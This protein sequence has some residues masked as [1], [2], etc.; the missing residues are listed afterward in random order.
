MVREL[1]DTVGVR[2]GYEGSNGVH[3]V[4][5]VHCNSVGALSHDLTRLVQN[6][7]IN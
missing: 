3:Y 4:K 1:P 5:H 7:K 2:I 6:R